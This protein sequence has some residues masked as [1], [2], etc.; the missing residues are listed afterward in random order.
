MTTMEKTNRNLGIDCLRAVSMLSVICLHIL[1]QGGLLSHTVAGSGKYCILNFLNILCFCAVDAYGIT[2]G[3]L[4]CD[5]PFRL[6]RL[7]KLWLTTVFWSV[8]VSCGFFLLVPGSR[9]L[10]EAVSMF[11][12]ILRGRYWFFTAYFVTMLVS[13]VL[14]VVIR[15]LSRGQFRALLAAL[16]VIFGVVP[17]CSLGYDVM[18]ISGGNHFAWMIGL[19]LI[20]GYIKVY[21]PQGGHVSR[22]NHRWLL[23]YLLLALVHLGYLL[24]MHL[25]GLGNWS[26][27]FLTNVSPLV[28]GEAV[29]LFLYFRERKIAPTGI[30]AK[31]IRF[32]TP[33]VY[34][35]YIIH[36]HPK[37]FWSD[38]L[39]ALLRPW[40]DWEVWKV[41][42]A[43]IG[44][45]LGVFVLCILA[46]K[47]R[48]WL[49]RV[50]KID[51]M[52][53]RLSC[54]VETGLRKCLMGKLEED[55]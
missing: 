23:Y 31:G 21:C 49:F 15:S 43:V 4:L 16:F 46:D 10:S 9:T 3:Y 36:V 6:S 12:P 11:L 18:R 26:G 41:L 45:A 52:A 39:I 2:T 44:A 5:R 1:G 55:L 35:V 34:A 48:Q 20:G 13:P 42:P 28:L 40:D 22:K 32:V 30:M 50:L 47:I 37:V 17:V 27:L 38:E 25:L 14:N 19:Y 54:R 53:D 33:G 8:A 24:L 7:G 51:A 29:C